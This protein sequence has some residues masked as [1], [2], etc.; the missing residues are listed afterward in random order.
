LCS[1]LFYFVYCWANWVAQHNTPGLTKSVLINDLVYIHI[2][3]ALCLYTQWQC[4]AYR[5]PSRDTMSK[6]HLYLAAAMWLL[7]LY[8]VALSIGGIVPFVNHTSKPAFTCSDFLGYIKVSIAFIKCMPQV[9]LNWKRQRTLGFSLGGV[10]FGLFGSGCVV[11]QMGVEAVRDRSW[12][13]II[14]NPTKILLAIDSIAFCLIFIVQHYVFYRENDAKYAALEATLTPE[15]LEQLEAA[16]A[17]A[18]AANNGKRTSSFGGGPGSS[19]GLLNTAAGLA[20]V[21]AGGGGV[22]PLLDDDCNGVDLERSSRASSTKKQLESSSLSHSHSHSP[23]PTG[24]CSLADSAPMIHL[25]M[26]GAGIEG[27]AQFNSS[28]QQQQSQRKSHR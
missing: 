7:A 1:F 18:A 8:T 20:L 26:E 10:L 22:V 4:F 15:Q 12:S 3:T 21:A 19:M 28:I 9:Y 2:S 5:V 13:P 25:T 17:A 27:V 23:G 11:G 16:E 6:T 24:Y 14:G